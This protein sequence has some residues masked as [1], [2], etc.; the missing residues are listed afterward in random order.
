MDHDHVHLHVESTVKQLA[1]AVNPH[2]F[3]GAGLGDGMVMSFH[4]GY[5][6]TILFDFWSTSSIALF[7]VSCLIL[8]VVA[9]LYEGI[10]LVREKLARYEARKNSERQAM[11]NIS[12][13]IRRDEVI[14]LN[15]E[16]NEE[17]KNESDAAT[18]I[19]HKSNDRLKINDESIYL[20]SYGSRLLSRGHILQTILHMLQITISYM[21][22]LVFM[23]YNSYLCVSVILGAGFGYFVFGLKRLNAIDQNYDIDVIIA[24]WTK[25]NM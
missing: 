14:N 15:Q 8:F 24:F 10:K 16:S 13:D 12:S 19:G 1:K 3:H 23:T 6:E 25:K 21:L 22:M 4:G 17:I 2:A 18:K 5:S 7:I 11:D 20:K 9:A